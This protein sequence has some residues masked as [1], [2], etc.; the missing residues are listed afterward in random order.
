[1]R[2]KAP[3]LMKNVSEETLPDPSL[4]DDF[5]MKEKEET[6]QNSRPEI[7]IISFWRQDIDMGDHYCYH[8]F[9][10]E[11]LKKVNNSL[12]KQR[13]N[14]EVGR[15]K[16]LFRGEENEIFLIFKKG[17]NWELGI[18]KIDHDEISGPNKIK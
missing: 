3:E 1:M 8:Y 6:P 16:C 10:M 5:P 17:R 14:A 13:F 15:S 18:L 4:S 2:Q 12:N 7:H 9:F 11:G